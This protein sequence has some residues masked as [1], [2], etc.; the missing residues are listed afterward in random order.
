MEKSVF[1]A[2]AS[3][4]GGMPFAARIRL[5][6]VGAMRQSFD[7]GFLDAISEEGFQALSPGPAR[8]RFARAIFDSH[9]GLSFSWVSRKRLG[10]IAPAQGDRQRILLQNIVADLFAIRNIAGSG[11]R[12][13]IAQLPEMDSMDAAIDRVWRDL[14]S[15]IRRTAFR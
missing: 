15:A 5:S 7:I 14:G 2:I 13:T 6:V 9:G 11:D 4:C 1:T 8:G 12:L 10:M 3:V